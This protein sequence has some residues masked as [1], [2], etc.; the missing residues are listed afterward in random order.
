MITRLQKSKRKCLVCHVMF[1]SKFYPC[2]CVSL[3][4]GY[5]DDCYVK[6][7]CESY[8]HCIGYCKSPFI[9]WPSTLKHKQIKQKLEFNIIKAHNIFA[10]LNLNL[11]DL[12]AL[13]KLQQVE[14]RTAKL[15][16]I[17]FKILKKKCAQT[18]RLIKMYTKPRI[19]LEECIEK[20]MN[21]NS[22]WYRACIEHIQVLTKTLEYTL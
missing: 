12:E 18:K 20:K 8:S 7:R 4:E 13:K 15:A 17:Y 2:Q 21:K 5:C 22:S 3:S 16:E 11:I 19:F 9:R 6:I 1:A 10:S 14:K